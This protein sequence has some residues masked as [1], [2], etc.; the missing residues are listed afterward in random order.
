MTYANQYNM[1][2]GTSSQRIETTT[3]PQA[4]GRVRR[5]DETPER[6]RRNKE[7]QTEISSDKDVTDA[8]LKF[9]FLPKI[10]ET[11]SL[12]ACKEPITM[13]RDFYQSLSYLANHYGLQPKSTKEFGYPYN[14]ALAIY[15]V[16][17]QLKIKVSDW[18]EVRLIKNKGK[19]FLTSEE[20][21]NTGATLYYIPI[22]PLY[23]LSKI[24]GYKKTY[25]LLL[26]V[27]SYLYHIADIPC[28]RQEGS[29]LYYM[30][31]MLKECFEEDDETADSVNLLNEIRI[32]EW[33]GDF[34]EQKIC[35]HKNL[36]LL[37]HR[38]KLFQ[39]KD[40][41]ETNCLEIARK[42]YQIFTDYPNNSI[43]TKVQ[44]TVK[45]ENDD[46]DD[47]IDNIVTMD[48]YISFCADVKGSLFENLFQNVNNELQEYGQIEEPVIIKHFDDSRVDFGSLDFE[49]Q[50]FNLIEELI[51]LLNNF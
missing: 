45:M 43:F 20:R 17:E 37:E 7:R 32:A 41:L 14:M 3:T 22:L 10:K 1:W 2:N 46:D 27:C 42:T 29:Y 15:D 31:E 47:E 23:R 39:P 50:I 4:V 30:Y 25:H 8:F 21:Y 49:N 11:K 36:E 33:V 51:D 40:D 38:I 12:Q 26:S 24:N 13:E 18:E 16:E 35:S 6:C 9:T 34:I 19:V 44:Q 5:L 48:K 28:Y